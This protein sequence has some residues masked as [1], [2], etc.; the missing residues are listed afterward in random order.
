MLCSQSCF[1]T[2]HGCWMSSCSWKKKSKPFFLNEEWCFW[3]TPHAHSQ[4]SS[5]L[6]HTLSNSHLALSLVLSFLLWC[7]HGCLENLIW[8]GLPCLPTPGK[9]RKIRPLSL[10]C[11]IKGQLQPA[12]FIIYTPK[13]C[14]HTQIPCCANKTGAV[15]WA[16]SW[17]LGKL[18]LSLYGR[19]HTT[20]PISFLEASSLGLQ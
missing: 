9:S 18:F 17:G 11:V 20:N 5:L 14:G 12:V 19:C 10:S 8:A 7:P 2:S 1:N 15:Q 6:G 16:F 13:S 4:T 3:R